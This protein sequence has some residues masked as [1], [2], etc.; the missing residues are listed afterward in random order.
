MTDVETNVETAIRAAAP[1]ALAA[2]VRRYDV[3]DQCEDAIQ[4]ALLE[5]LVRWRENGVPE[6]PTGWLIS[7]ATRRLMDG[8]RRDN[9]R[10]Q[11]EL[12]DFLRAADPDPE[13]Y[14][15][16]SDDTVRLL[17]LCCHPALTPASQIALTLR[18][19][20]GLTTAEVAAALLVSE[21]TVAQR[22]SRAKRMIA[23][24]RFELPTAEE[25][26]VRLRAV[27]QVLYLIFNEGHTASAGASLQR[28]DLA[29]E[30]LRITR[31]LEHAVGANDKDNGEVTG[32]L[33]L[34]ILTH[35][36]RDA[37]TGPGGDLIPADRQ[38]R[39]RWHADELA[40]GIRLVEGVLRT[41]AVGPYQLEAAIA[42]VHSEADSVETTDWA[43]IAGLYRLLERVDPSPMVRLGSA[44]A[45]AMTDGPDA[46]IA[47]VEELADDKYV[48]NHH[49]R[50]SVLAHLHELAGRPDLARSN[51]LAALER[52]RNAAEQ[53]YLRERIAHLIT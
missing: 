9:A 53:N 16:D 20:G 37:R 18:S 27:L 17:V 29:A 5:A 44:V 15:E 6:Q 33:A 8:W 35:A 23:G 12:N 4:E 2:L 51:Y 7:V 30:A 1:R 45:I 38:D 22:I 50:L 21:T 48:G 52:T 46:G 41:G 34:M 25:Y 19:V 28:V 49:R 43:Q 3:F 36:R 26:D 11:R 42:A 10:R 14:H 39:S 32:L 47:I 13:D 31:L 40:E 24:A